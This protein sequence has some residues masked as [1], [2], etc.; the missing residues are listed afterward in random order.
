VTRSTGRDQASKDAFG[1]LLKLRRLE[2]ELSVL[3][4]QSELHELGKPVSEQA[5]R[6]WEKGRA[7]PP[8]TL[9]PTLAQVLQCEVG[10]LVPTA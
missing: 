9:L 6:N 7:L 10:D 1:K 2:A 4:V 5:W 8:L 3:G